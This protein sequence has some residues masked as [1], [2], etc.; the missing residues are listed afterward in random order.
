MSLC[1]YKHSLG[2]PNKGFHQHIGGVAMGD[3]IG[4]LLIVWLIVYNTHW[5]FSL[6]AA[7]AFGLAY[8]LHRL[9]CIQTK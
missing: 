4:T 7:V 9:F 3:V 2:I 5:D 6:V 8:V 1:K